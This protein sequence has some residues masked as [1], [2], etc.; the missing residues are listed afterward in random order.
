MVHATFLMECQARQNPTGLRI[1]DIK[2]TE[3]LVRIWF[4]EKYVGGRL[5]KCEWRGT[6]QYF[7]FGYKLG[8]FID[9]SDALPEDVTLVILNAYDV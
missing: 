5:L 1:L 7:V 8:S 9:P 2:T 3:R 4:F 6:L